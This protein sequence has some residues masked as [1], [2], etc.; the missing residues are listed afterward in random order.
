MPGKRRRGRDIVLVD[1]SGIRPRR[2]V[3]REPRRGMWRLI[4][5]KSRIA[6]GRALWAYPGRVP[7]ASLTLNADGW[8]A[9]SLGLWSPPGAQTR[10][11]ARLSGEK[12]WQELSQPLPQENI[13]TVGDFV[14]DQ[15][16]PIYGF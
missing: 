1:F 12:A 11:R 7:Q 10:I 4:P 3:S 6:A 8:Y 5:W 14:V 9:I 15:C 16:P 13:H 2:A